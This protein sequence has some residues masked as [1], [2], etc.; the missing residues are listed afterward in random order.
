LPRTSWSLAHE[1]VGKVGQADPPDCENGA[2]RPRSLTEICG[3]IRDFVAVEEGPQPPAQV[4]D[5]ANTRRTCL[6]LG[7]QRAFGSV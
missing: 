2:L 4:L 6:R 5:S 1:Q 7:L 3:N